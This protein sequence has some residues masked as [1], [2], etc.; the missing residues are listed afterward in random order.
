MNDQTK[1]LATNTKETPLQT[2]ANRLSVD[3]EKMQNI[4]MATV[5][6]SGNNSPVITD[7][8]FTSFLI[9]ANEYHLNP[10]VKE[11]YAF[12]AK[13]GGI[14]PIVS[15]DGWIKIAQRNKNY[16]GHE[17]EFSETTIK[18]NGAEVPEWCKCSIYR[19][20]LDKPIVFIEYMAE[21][22]MNTEPWKKKPRRMLSHKVFIQCSRYAFGISGIMDEDDGLAA[23]Q[24]KDITPAKQTSALNRPGKDDDKTDTVVV[25]EDQAETIGDVIKAAIEAEV[26]VDRLP[27]DD[28]IKAIEA[29]ETIEQLNAAKEDGQK[30]ESGTEEF[31]Q[32]AAAY[33]GRKAVLNNEA[34]NKK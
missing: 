21:C 12:P 32:M 33:Q 1:E 14:Q 6:P 2:M 30:W 22:Y 11:I 20:D 19:K 28:I 29:S 18:Q 23:Q 34:A 15:I 7:E 10:L 8:I 5:M 26:A 25:V 31:N 3:P 9:V 27:V 16:N 4:I 17:F 24:E 13:G